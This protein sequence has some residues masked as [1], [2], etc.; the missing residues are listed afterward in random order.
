M[1]A[2]DQAPEQMKLR[3][4]VANGEAWAELLNAYHEGPR[5]V[6]GPVVIERMMGLL[7]QTAAGF[8]TYP[9]GVDAEDVW[10]QLVL[11]TLE[12][13]LGLPVPFEARWIPRLLALRAKAGVRRWLEREALSA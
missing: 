3:M 11:E 2:T 5:E 13:A 7:R 4:V 9:P 12:A 8:T 10:Q 6:W 1:E